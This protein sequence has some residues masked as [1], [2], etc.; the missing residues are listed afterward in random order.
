MNKKRYLIVIIIGVVIGIFIIHPLTV[1]IRELFYWHQGYWHLHWYEL[2]AAFQV[3]YSYSH[4]PN[5]FLYGILSGLVSFFWFR[6]NNTYRKIADQY[7]RFALIGREASTIVHDINSP[8]FGI[9]AFTDLVQ[10]DLK[11]EQKLDYCRRIKTSAERI[12]SLV[13]EIKTLA[14]GEGRITV[15]KQP[16]VLS[17]IV[18]QTAK[19]INLRSRLQIDP[20]A[21]EEI[22]LDPLYFGRVL[23]NLLKNADDALAGSES[24]VIEVSLKSY[25]DRSVIEIA[26]NGPGI[27]VSIRKDLFRFGSTYGKEHGT[28]LGLY[29]S[30][31]IVEAHGGIITFRDR[32]NGG[33]VF[34]ISLPRNQLQSS[35]E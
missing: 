13:A 31:R 17:E 7:E 33:T 25:S 28:G 20:S 18:K 2:V 19:E 29:A 3:A 14:T 11:D 27:P 30:R 24:A 35:S 26:D 34:I 1:L 23:L 10:E 22:P 12:S 6:S 16:V 21:Q 8:L 5:A 15:K 32:D 9:K 4:L